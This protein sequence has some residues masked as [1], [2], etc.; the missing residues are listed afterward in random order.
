VLISS[1]LLLRISGIEIG[2]PLSPV[3]N[4][5]PYVLP[6]AILATVLAALLRQWPATVLAGVTALVL[7]LL[8]WPR[9]AG[10]PDEDVQG[11]ELSVMSANVLRGGSDVERLLELARE[12]D[13]EVLALQELTP[14]F[15]RQFERAGG[16][17]LFPHSL[18]KL[19]QRVSGNGLY[20]RY[21]LKQIPVGEPEPHLLFAEM[22]VEPDMAVEVASVHPLAPLGR[23]SMDAWR[24]GL[25][26]TPRA[27]P[28]GAIRIL[29][30]DFNAG[31]DNPEFRDIVYS[32]YEDAAEQLGQGLETTWP[33]KDKPFFYLPVT[34]DHVLFD[35]RVGARSFETFELPDSDHRTIHADLVVPD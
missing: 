28:D 13:A 3:M 14:G 33:T 21:P 30:G 35:A 15:A 32:G 26:N 10:G 23:G 5:T 34:I 11:R 29:L 17:E 1:W 9:F 4:Y 27:E 12:H 2:F 22:K 19:R 8:I 20:S 24:R 18:L 31:F 16:G 25:E 7:F 6:V